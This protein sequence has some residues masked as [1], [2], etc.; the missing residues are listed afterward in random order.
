MLRNHH[1]ALYRKAELARSLLLQFRSNEGRHRVSFALFGGDITDYKRLLLGFGDQ[2][3]RLSFITDQ[4]FRFLKLVVKAAGLHRLIADFQQARIERGRLLTGEVRANRPI[5]GLS[6]GFD[7][8]FALDHH[9]QRD[10]LHAA[11]T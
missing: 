9:A 10:G 1:G 7:F 2:V 11:R 3:F 8:A 5:F 6:K 4:D